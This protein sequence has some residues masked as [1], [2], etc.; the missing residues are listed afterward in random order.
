MGASDN[1][2][3]MPYTHTDYS[4]HTDGACSGNP[5]P[6]GWGAVILHHIGG[7]IINR[8]QP[9]G[10]HPATTNNQM[11]LFAAIRGVLALACSPYFDP[12]LPIRVY[13]DSE[14]VVL[15]MAERLAKWKANGWRTSDKKPVKNRELWE[16]LDETVQGLNIEW[17]WTKGHAGDLLNEQADGLARKGMEPFLPA[18]A[19]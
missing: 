10:G 4:I 6:G 3:A 11:E 1:G 18:A 17:L 7:Q 13:S 16:K 5:G 12:S 2:I 8:L 14:Y 9:F 15:G 19:A